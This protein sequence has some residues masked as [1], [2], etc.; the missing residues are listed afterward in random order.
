MLPCSFGKSLKGALK[1]LNDEYLI[2]I[3]NVQS[4]PQTED[5]QYVQPLLELIS[6]EAEIE[7]EFPS[8]TGGD[9]P[10]VDPEDD[11]PEDTEDET[12]EVE[13]PGFTGDEIVDTFSL[14]EDVELRGAYSVRQLFDVEF[15]IQVFHL[16]TSETLDIG[17]DE[18][19][20]LDVAQV[21]QFIDDAV[22]PG[23]DIPV[24]DATIKV[25]KWY[26]QS[27]SGHHAAI[28]DPLRAPSIAREGEGISISA[29]N[30]YPEIRFQDYSSSEYNASDNRCL[31]LNFE[32][33]WANQTVFAGIRRD[34][35]P[36]DRDWET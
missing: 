13:E 11:V 16:I 10:E 21:Q 3:V 27:G 34:G 8:D 5:L 12:T 25:I 9:I 2:S 22:I 20:I 32:T 23:T 29:R 6:A 28:S 4:I 33:S 26:D 31:P 36:T 17:F 1:A 14:L 24:G 18:N 35:A 19:G 7:V 15:C 30:G